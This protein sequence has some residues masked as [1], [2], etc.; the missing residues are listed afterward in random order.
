M[1]E[2]RPAEQNTSISG[3]NGYPLFRLLRCEQY[4]KNLLVPAPLFCSGELF[5]RIKLSCGIR[6]FLVFCLASSFVYILNDILDMERDRLHPQKKYRPLAAG[7]V[8]VR[9]A[10]VLAGA[11][12][13]AAVLLNGTVFS[14]ASAAVL[15]CFLAVNAAYSLGLKNIPILDLALLVSGFFFRLQYG[16]LITG[17]SVSGWLYLT[18]MAMAFYFALAKRKSERMHAGTA[19]RDVLRHYSD[20][21]LDRNL[22]LFMGLGIVFYALWSMDEATLERHG[23]LPLFVT[24][25]CL[26]LLILR[27]QTDMEKDTTENPAEV[28]F[29]DPLLLAGGAAFMLFLF[30]CFYLL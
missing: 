4:I 27:F 13:A 21:F 30:I 24:V 17:I 18:V 22:S 14:P 3:K 7:I 20:A 15:F 11:L 19:G 16:A 12:L 25:P 6:G 26:I 29:H 8:S 5:D 9:R 2:V 10:A 1:S 28:V 23:S